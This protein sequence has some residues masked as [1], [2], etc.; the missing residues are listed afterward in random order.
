MKEL[1]EQEQMESTEIKFSVF[2]VI[3]CVWRM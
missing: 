2:S 1:V 3:S